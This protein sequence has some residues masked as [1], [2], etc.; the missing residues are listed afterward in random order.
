M[1]ITVAQQCL[2]HARGAD[3]A[4]ERLGYL[5]TAV[6][7]LKAAVKAARQAALEEAAGQEPLSLS[8]IKG[9]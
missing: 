1:S 2:A 7:S 6:E 8:S 3:T 9:R 5:T 4:A